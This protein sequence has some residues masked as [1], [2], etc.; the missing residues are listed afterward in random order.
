MEG[1]LINSRLVCSSAEHSGHLARVSHIGLCTVVAR[2]PT[3]RDQSQLLASVLAGDNCDKN[4]VCRTSSIA[5]RRLG[6]RTHRQTVGRSE[7]EG[8]SQQR[9]SLTF[10]FGHS[11][12]ANFRSVISVSFLLNAR[13]MHKQS[14]S[15]SFWNVELLSKIGGSSCPTCRTDLWKPPH[16]E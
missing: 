8:A 6:G 13:K 3:P 10:C 2:L 15:L 16:C 14:F 11:L 4:R 9:G 12:P 5:R 1:C 7:F